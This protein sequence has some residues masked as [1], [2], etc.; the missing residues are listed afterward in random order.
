MTSISL[1]RVVAIGL[2]VMLS[3]PALAQD[4]PQGTPANSIQV[5]TAVK[6]PTSFERAERMEEMRYQHL[7]MAYAFIW[8]IIFLFVYRTWKLNQATVEELRS[9]QRRIASLEDTDGGE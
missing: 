8:L 3:A 2:T 5:D 1:I 6:T 9:L 7:W 4:A